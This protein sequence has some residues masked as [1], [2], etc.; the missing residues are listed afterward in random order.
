MKMSLRVDPKEKAYLR[1][2]DYFIRDSRFTW[3]YYSTLFA[4]GS[5]FLEQVGDKKALEELDKHVF[6]LEDD[7]YP[8]FSSLYEVEDWMF[9][10][11]FRNEYFLGRGARRMEEGYI[12]GRLHQIGQWLDKQVN[13]HIGKVRFSAFGLGKL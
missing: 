6:D 5:D 7:C 10:T 11:I 1:F 2:K 8:S 13:R 12:R 4:L 3:Q 9:S